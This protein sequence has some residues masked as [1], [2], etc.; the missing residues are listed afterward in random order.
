VSLDTVAAAFQI[1]RPKAVISGAEV[2]EL[3][4]AGRFAEIWIYCCVD[5]DTTAEIYRLM[6]S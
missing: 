2:P 4:R 5:V 1:P 6:M 3:A